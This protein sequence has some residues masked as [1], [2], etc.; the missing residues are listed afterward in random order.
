MGILISVYGLESRKRNIQAVSK[1]IYDW[2]LKARPAGDDKF[3]YI[4]EHKPNQDL[5]EQIPAEDKHIRIVAKRNIAED[6]WSKEAH[7]FTA[8]R[9]LIITLVS[10]TK[11]DSWLDKYAEVILKLLNHTDPVKRGF[12]RSALIHDE[13]LLEADQVPPVLDEDVVV[14]III[15]SAVIES[16]EEKGV[17]HV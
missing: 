1:T 6:G 11:E 16:V 5:V 4:D 10:S 8:S 13:R 7:R 2:L 17:S 12:T 15:K 9:M 14:H 3:Q